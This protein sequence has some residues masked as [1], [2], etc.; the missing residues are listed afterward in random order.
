MIHFNNCHIHLYV[1]LIQFQLSLADLNN[2]DL[3]TYYSQCADTLRW[4]KNPTQ[5]HHCETCNQLS[6]WQQ[7]SGTDTRLMCTVIKRAC[8][9]RPD[10]SQC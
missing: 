3:A 4:K 2:V 8:H 7:M 5:L 10:D 1:H 9:D 6:D